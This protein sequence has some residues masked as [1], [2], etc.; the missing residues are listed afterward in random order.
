MGGVGNIG[1]DPLM[2]DPDGQDDAIGTEDDNV[3]LAPG[4]PAINAGDPGFI[5]SD[6]QTDS[7]GY[8]R[9]LC[10]GLDIGAYEFGMGDADC[11]GDMDTVDFVES[12][13]C[14]A[15]PGEPY[16]GA[17]E[18]FDFDGDDDID[19]ADMRAFQLAFTGR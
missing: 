14:Q 15:G 7:D 1:A 5:P 11:D 19:W 10:G 4:S 18:M 6:N 16:I 17:C 8:P 2:I 13:S 9:V 12:W 3:R